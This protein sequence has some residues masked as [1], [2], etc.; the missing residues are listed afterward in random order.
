MFET[1]HAGFFLFAFSQNWSHN[2]LQITKSCG[3]EIAKIYFRACTSSLC[4]FKGIN[5]PI[6]VSFF[7]VIADLE[8]LKQKADHFWN[9]EEQPLTSIKDL[10]TDNQISIIGNLTATQSPLDDQA[11]SIRDP[12]S[13]VDLNISFG[14]KSCLQDPFTCTSG[15]TVAMVI[16]LGQGDFK[17]DIFGPC[18]GTEGMKVENSFFHLFIAPLH[19]IGDWVQVP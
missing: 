13:R 12:Q 2:A 8:R 18:G 10:K 19:T 4:I 5:H 16:K 11:I 3:T 14:N 9:F 15:L 6:N 7:A 17:T 1:K